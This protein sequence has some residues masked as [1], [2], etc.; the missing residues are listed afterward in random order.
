MWIGIELL[1][2]SS[3]KSSIFGWNLRK[4]AKKPWMVDCN[5]TNWKDFF[6]FHQRSLFLVK[7]HFVAMIGVTSWDWD[8]VRLIVMKKMSTKNVCIRFFPMAF[9]IRRLF[10]LDCA[11]SAA[12]IGWDSS[13]GSLSTFFDESF[14]HRGESKCARC[15]QW[16]HFLY[17][18]K[19]ATCKTDHWIII[20][21]M[22]VGREIYTMFIWIFLF[23]DFWRILYNE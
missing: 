13:I 9:F 23:V 18:H 4:R 2:F 10:P 14:F 5:R 17:A 12:A 16:R 3:I 20:N 11:K 1:F 21:R 6:P 7:L 15:F 8:Q 19:K 22:I